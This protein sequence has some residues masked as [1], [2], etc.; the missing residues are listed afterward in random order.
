MRPFLSHFS[1]CEEGRTRSPLKTLLDP[2]QCLFD[3]SRAFEQFWLCVRDG[4]SLLCIRD[5]P[6]GHKSV[7]FSSA[8]S[9]K[10]PLHLC[11]AMWLSSHQWIQGQIDVS[12]QSQG[13]W[14]QLCLIQLALPLPPQS[15]RLCDI[16]SRISKVEEAWIPESVLV[17]RF[18]GSCPTRT[19]LYLIFH[20][21]KNMICC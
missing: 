7:F 13:S 9:P 20:E 19:S 5:W 4:L 12:F 8:H 15:W 3:Q 17:G 14:E 18:E 1:V 16:D 21:W 11:R 6:G 10:P 2:N